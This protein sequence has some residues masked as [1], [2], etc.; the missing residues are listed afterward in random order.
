MVD[1][2]GDAESVASHGSRI[3]DAERR[4][5]LEV[6]KEQLTAAR[7]RVEHSMS[8]AGSARQDAEVAARRIAELEEVESKDL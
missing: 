7:M 2:A 1:R 3:I 4:E 6:A 8:E 5:K